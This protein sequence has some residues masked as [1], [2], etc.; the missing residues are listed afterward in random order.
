MES[1][2]EDFKGSEALFAL[3]RLLGTVSWRDSV[4]LFSDSAAT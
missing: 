3:R 2:L 1:T 4:P